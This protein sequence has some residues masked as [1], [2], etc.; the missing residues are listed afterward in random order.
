MKLFSSTIIKGIVI[1]LAIIFAGLVCYAV[2]AHYVGTAPHETAFQPFKQLNQPLG[3]QLELEGCFLRSQDPSGFVLKALSLSPQVKL[4]ADRPVKVQFVMRNINTADTLVHGAA[5]DE[6]IPQEM[7]MRVSLEVQPSAPKTVTFRSTRE[8][9]EFDFYVIGDNRSYHKVM[10]EV[11]L[12]SNQ[13]RPLFIF[14]TGDLVKSATPESMLEHEDF[15]LKASV[16]YFTAI[17][18]HDLDEDNKADDYLKLFGPTYYRFSYAGVL[19]IVLDNSE[20]FISFKQLNWLEDQLEDVSK[21]R[22]VIVFAHQPPLDPR[23]GR[24]H[25]MKPIIGGSYFLIKKLKKAHPNLLFICGHIHS[26]YDFRVNDI[27]VVISGGA[28]AG[29]SEPFPFYHY[30]VLQVRN[31]SIKQKL[32]QVDVEVGTATDQVTNGY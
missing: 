32:V 20:G 31:N 26:Y 9:S 11:F 4:S 1:L 12:Q 2:G 28:G 17:G 6:K 30:L 24:H 3:L 18:N 10:K 21:F 16:P 5:I 14:H 8:K 27:H 7:A 22:R 15:S 13:E 19:F 23:R 29:R 25:G